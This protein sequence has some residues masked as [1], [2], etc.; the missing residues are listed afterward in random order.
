M[1]N[2]VDFLPFAIGG[3]ANVESQAAWVS[4]AVV[5]NGFQSGITLSIQ[6]N[7]AIRQA[8]V[9]AAT[10]AN[11][12][13]QILN[14]SVFD[15]GSVA[16]LEVQFWQTML[17]SHYFTDSGSANTIVITEPSGLSFPAPVAGTSIL[18]LIAASNTGAT[19]L[20]WMG[21]GAVAVTTQAKGA[22]SSTTILSGGIYRFCFDGTEWQYIS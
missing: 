10:W 16:G 12:A 6:V 20:N 5:T 2:T 1:T 18:V 7:K 19:T 11:L 13:S 17:Q 3:S 9:V 21:H 4:D 14:A 15:N 22:L 8:S